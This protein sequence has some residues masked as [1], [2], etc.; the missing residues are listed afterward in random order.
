MP[1]CKTRR[2]PTAKKPGPK[3]DSG[4]PR[5]LAFHPMAGARQRL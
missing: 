4:V 3:T 1:K 5:L 2:V